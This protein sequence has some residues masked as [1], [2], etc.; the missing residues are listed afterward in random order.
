[1]GNFFLKHIYL[2][3]SKISS[4]AK[5]ASAMHKKIF[6]RMTSGF[7]ANLSIYED[8]SSVVSRNLFCRQRI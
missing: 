5:K 2:I 7:T 1:M 8:I 3:T 4:K 6:M